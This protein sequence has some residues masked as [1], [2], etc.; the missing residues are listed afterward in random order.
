MGPSVDKRFLYRQKNVHDVPVE[1]SFVRL[2]DSE[3]KTNSSMIKAAFRPLLRTAF[4]YPYAALMPDYH[5]GEGSMIGSV[6]PTKEVL[7]PSVIGGDLGCGMTAVRLGVEA[8]SIR[9]EFQDI[10]KILKEVVP[11]GTAHNGTVTE[12]VEADGIW[13]RKVFAPVLTNRLRRKLLR[14]FAS[15]G[16]GNHFLEIQVDSQDRLWVMLHSGSR[17]LGVR[18]RDYYVAQ[19]GNQRG[20]ERKLYSKIPYLMTDGELAEH[21]LSDLQFAIDFARHSRKEMMMRVLE[22]LSDHCPEF[23]SAREP[24]LITTAY[25]VAHNYVTEEEHFGEKLVVHRKGAIRVREGEVGLVPGS[26]GT[27]SYVVQGRGNEFSFC[28]CSHGAGRAMSRRQAFLKISD[29]EFGKSMEGVVYEH[30][31]RIKDEAP[32]AYKDIRRVMRGQKDLVKIIYELRPLISIKGWQ[33]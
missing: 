3:G 14:Q 12:R 26:M 32:I 25:D 5:P 8:D 6:I 18:I 2:W 23:E 31:D 7:L 1:G 19:G 29:R 21:Y 24:G 11:V 16:G 4:V 30:N 9:P 27:G 13:H 22:V 10:L 33:I 20:I 15:L 17:Y 28:S